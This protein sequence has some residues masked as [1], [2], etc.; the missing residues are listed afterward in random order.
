MEE[1]KKKISSYYKAISKED[2]NDVQVDMLIDRTQIYLNRKD[3]NVILAGTLAQILYE[4]NQSF[5]KNKELQIS[6]I[7]DNGQSVSYSQNPASALVSK[8]DS[9]LFGSHTAILNRFRRIGVLG[10]NTLKP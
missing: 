8:N 6:S 7:S 10:A 9:D 1:L 3:I 5:E 4:T 2:A